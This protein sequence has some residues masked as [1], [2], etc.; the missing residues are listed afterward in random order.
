MIAVVCVDDRNGTLFHNRRQSQDRGLREDLLSLCP[1]TLRMN[2]YSARLFSGSEERLTVSEDFLEEAGQGEWCFVENSPLTPWM[3][4]IETLVLYRWNRAYPA[5][6]HLD[7][8]LDDFLLMDKIDFPG[9]S[10]ETLTRETYQRPA[11]PPPEE[12]APEPEKTA[13]PDPSLMAQLF[14]IPS[15]ADIQLSLFKQEEE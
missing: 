6:T 9:S 7:I 11:P 3:E 8:S 1:G 4:K 14:S 2:G 10:H 12:P 15:F 13:D 5:D